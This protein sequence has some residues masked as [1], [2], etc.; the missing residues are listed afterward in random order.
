MSVLSLNM[1]S[2]RS[3]NRICLHIPSPE[4][5]YAITFCYVCTV[6]NGVLWFVKGRN[7]HG[8]LHTIAH[9]SKL[10]SN[11]N[12][13]KA[14]LHI[15][16]EV[17]RVFNTNRQV[18]SRDRMTGEHAFNDRLGNLSDDVRGSLNKLRSELLPSNTDSIY[19]ELRRSPPVDIVPCN[20]MVVPMDDNNHSSGS[21]FGGL[22]GYMSPHNDK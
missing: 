9:K 12:L 18:K 21:S 16:G 7:S 17:Y 2:I 6:I 13:T 3:P 1:T 5:T 8:L 10:D 14:R 4:T 15:D 11:A 19:S 22:M 20:T